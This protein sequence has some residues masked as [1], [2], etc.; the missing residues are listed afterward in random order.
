MKLCRYRK[1]D[2]FGQKLMVSSTTDAISLRVLILDE[3]N[4]FLNLLINYEK[5]HKPV[6]ISDDFNACVEW[7]SILTIK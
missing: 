7:G 5:F 2:M 3:F 4:E 6:V 1:A